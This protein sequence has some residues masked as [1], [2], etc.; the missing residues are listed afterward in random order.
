MRYYIIILIILTLI[1]PVFCD[2][3]Q[4]IELLNTNK[5]TLIQNY[6]VILESDPWNYEIIIKRGNALFLE[7]HYKQALSDF[8]KIENSK[9]MNGIFYLKKG[10]CNTELKQ[11]V[12]AKTDLFMAIKSLPDDFRPYLEL[13]KIFLIEKKAR[14]ALYY[15]NKSEVL[16]PNFTET[17]KLK[18]AAFLKIGNFKESRK[19]FDKYSKSGGK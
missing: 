4:E 11:Y 6:N 1:T 8:N 2:N 12:S 7:K 3:S 9:N 16:N 5:K 14:N 18:G 13:G 15:L 19:Y 17:M 10:I